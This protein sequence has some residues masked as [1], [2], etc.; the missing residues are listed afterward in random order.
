MVRFDDIERYCLTLANSSEWTSETKG[1]A[2]FTIRS[3]IGS[4]YNPELPV[5]FVDIK[6]EP[7]VDI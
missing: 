7:R 4:K 5:L 2:G 1:A 3:K 6:L